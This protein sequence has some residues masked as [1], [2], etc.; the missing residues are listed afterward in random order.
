MGVLVTQRWLPSFSRRLYRSS[1]Q[2]LARL[3]VVLAILGITLVAGLFAAAR[4]SPEQLATQGTGAFEFSLAQGPFLD[5]G[6][7]VPAASREAFRAGGAT[8]WQFVLGYHVPFKDQP[9]WSAVL[10]AD[11][12]SLPMGELYELISGRWPTA[13]NEVVVTSD[14]AAAA[15]DGTLRA[16]DDALQ[17]KVVGIV[18]NQ[19]YLPGQH[20]LTVPGTWASLDPATGARFPDL[21]ASVSTFWNGGDP[22]RVVHE[23][24]AAWSSSMPEYSAEE[25]PEVLALGLNQ[26]AETIAQQRRTLA[27]SPAIGLPPVLGLAGLAG[28]AVAALNV[29]WRTRLI[30]QCVRLGIQ[31]RHVELALATA[32]LATI[33]FGVLV[34]AAAGM[35]ALVPGRAIL[36]TRA[37]AAL[38]PMAL[39]WRVWALSLTASISAYVLVTGLTFLVGRRTMSR[40]EAPGR[41]TGRVLGGFRLFVAVASI[42][43]AVGFTTQVKDQTGMGLVMSLLA[44]AAGC[45]T[46]SVAT[47]LAARGTTN[48]ADL[49]ARR[50]IAREGRR[51][52]VLGGV[53]CALVCVLLSGMTWWTSGNATTNDLTRANIPEG[54]VALESPGDLPANLISEFE[55]FTGLTEPVRV[56]LVSTTSLSLPGRLYAVATA[57]DL[58]RLTRS[59]LT[60]EQIRA[61]ESGG[62]LISEPVGAVTVSTTEATFTIPAVQAPIPEE[63]GAAAFILLPAMDSGLEVAP[64]GSFFIYP[65]VDEAQLAKVKD[66]ADALG[67]S[68]ALISWH[69]P[70]DVIPISLSSQVAMGGLGL[71]VLIITALGSLS[72][73]R[74]MRPVLAVT[75]A[76]GLDR[77]WLERV[78]REQALIT[79][80]AAFAVAALSQVLLLA[81][82]RTLTTITVVT[83]W[84]ATTTV[85]VICIG[86]LWL[87]PTLALTQLNP[88]EREF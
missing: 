34:G 6:Q 59:Q 82:L 46:P 54:M 32:G 33:L 79:F 1:T 84:A 37:E 74:A 9:Q 80:G 38:S 10:E 58:T 4:P 24:A 17:L 77:R 69:R 14:V 70:P 8:S 41:P 40:R 55:A 29:R 68:P 44:L 83:P 88:T 28:V 25:L 45:L 35:L 5:P 15:L 72:Q 76:I 73:A 61:L 71:V 27:N 67:Y 81:M 57:D 23:L 19:A 39:E 63:F 62:L 22:N 7:D 2:H 52:R 64:Q 86:G 65:E 13:P 47:R 12:A 49:L 85:A 30:E 31:R 48:P 51:A 50:A 66:A 21:K 53:T 75:R 56:D 11:W 87:A 26:R 16:V 36:T 43:A 60:P 42:A 3:L 18:V 78:L 20:V